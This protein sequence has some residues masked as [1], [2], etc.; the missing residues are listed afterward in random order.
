ML[1][2]IHT[3]T[4]KRYCNNIPMKKQFMRLGTQHVQVTSKCLSVHTH[5]HTHT[6]NT[7]YL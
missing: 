6:Y 2:R 3:C 4:I 1:E 7:P 5:A